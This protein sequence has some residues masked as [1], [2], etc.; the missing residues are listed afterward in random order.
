M[1]TKDMEQELFGT[2]TPEGIAM[3]DR[4]YNRLCSCNCD[5]GFNF[6]DVR[7]LK[8]AFHVIEGI[9]YTYSRRIK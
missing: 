4:I 2:L 3:L 1:S 7:D 8:A 5:A 9:F 6:V